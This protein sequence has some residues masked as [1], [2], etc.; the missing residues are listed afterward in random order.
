M[1]EKCWEGPGGIKGAESAIKQLGGKIK[2][3]QSFKLPKTD[4]GRSLIAIEKMKKLSG[5]YPRKAG[6]PSKEPLG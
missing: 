4:M 6:L 5:K 2:S 1:P 3:I